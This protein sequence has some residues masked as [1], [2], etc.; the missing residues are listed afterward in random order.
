MSTKAYRATHKKEQAALAKAWY[1]AHRQLS[2]ERA[3]AW[4]QAHPWERFVSLAASQL[5][6][7]EGRSTNAS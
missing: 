6:Q 2:I 7:L 1:A 3:V 4:N 5:K